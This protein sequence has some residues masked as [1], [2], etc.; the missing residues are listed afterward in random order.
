[1]EETKNEP[2]VQ[3]TE[4]AIAHITATMERQGLA[5]QGLRIGLEKGGCSG[6]EYLV[7]F[8]TEA[9]DDDY[10]YEV[11][12]LRIFIDRVSSEKLAGA[13]LDYVDGLVGAGLKFR[14]PQATSTC[15]CGTSFSTN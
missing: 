15:G 5:G 14:N 2:V 1:M 9:Q 12:Q 8:A 6:Y 13:V 7:E 4:A 3:L 11:G 10:V